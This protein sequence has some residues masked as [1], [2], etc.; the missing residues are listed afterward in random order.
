MKKFLSWLFDHG[1]LTAYAFLV[2]VSLAISGIALLGAVLLAHWW[3][4]IK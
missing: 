4:K 2:S 3:S 1:L